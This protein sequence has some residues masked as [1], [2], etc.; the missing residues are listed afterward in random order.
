[1]LTYHLTNAVAR[2]ELLMYLSTHEVEV[3]IVGASTLRARGRR[4]AKLVDLFHQLHP[5]HPR[6]HIATSPR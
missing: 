6:T 5:T 2:D 1:M 4:V 3:T